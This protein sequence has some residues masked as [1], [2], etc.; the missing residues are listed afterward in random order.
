MNDIMATAAVG[1]SVADIDVYTRQI[2]TMERA[3][4]SHGPSG[5]CRRQRDALFSTYVVSLAR[6]IAGEA[7]IERR[8]AMTRIALESIPE[9]VQ[10][11]TP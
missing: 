1:S 7:G 9:L 5:E 8:K 11:R 6:L 10:Q 3:A 4:L 2:L